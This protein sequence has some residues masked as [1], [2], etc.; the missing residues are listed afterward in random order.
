M[1]GMRTRDYIHSASVLFHCGFKIIFILKWAVIVINISVCFAG[2]KTDGKW[3]F[4]ATQQVTDIKNQTLSRAGKL[5]VCYIYNERDI[6][7]K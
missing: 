1:F 3:R 4:E 6:W 5:Y 7:K 2:K